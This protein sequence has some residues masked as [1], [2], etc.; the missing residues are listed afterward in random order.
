[1]RELGE[2]DS[3]PAVFIVD[4]AGVVRFARVGN[5][6][7]DRVSVRELLSE[8]AKLSPAP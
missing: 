3:L 1:M 7:V 2:E 4:R 6:I 5:N 8:L